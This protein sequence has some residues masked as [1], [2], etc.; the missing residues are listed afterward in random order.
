MSKFLVCGAGGFIGGH[1]VKSLLDEGQEV[2]CV[3]IKPI[4]N[5]FQIFNENKNSV[6]YCL[7]FA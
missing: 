3:D 1:L 2:V 7:E 5:W 6:P 4:E